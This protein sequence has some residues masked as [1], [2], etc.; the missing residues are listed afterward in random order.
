MHSVETIL[1]ILNFDL[2]QGQQQAVYLLVLLSSSRELNSWT[3]PG[4]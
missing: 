4:S 1:L 3:S 2:F